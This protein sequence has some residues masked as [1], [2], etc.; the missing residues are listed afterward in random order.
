LLSEEN[1]KNARGVRIIAVYEATKGFLI[2]AVGIGL[3]A[4]VHR[5]LQAL[6]E[7]LVEHLH[8]N[9]AG[10]FSQ[11][12]V[13]AAKNLTDAKLRVAATIAFFDA[14]L[15]LVQAYGLW[16]LFAWAEWLTIASSAIYLPIEI[17]EIFHKPTALR[18]F[19]FLANLAIVIYLLRVRLTKKQNAPIEAQNS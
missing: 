15:R 16:H 10:H 7:S 2:L 5:D 12:F 14:A 1:K 19:I 11:I 3:L 17:Y 8:F 13:E 18:G 9:P 6:A 4:L